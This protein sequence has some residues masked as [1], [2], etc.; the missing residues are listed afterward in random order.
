MSAI[1]P[2]AKTKR[3]KKKNNNQV[4]LIPTTLYSYPNLTSDCMINFSSIKDFLSSSTK[5]SLSFG[6]GPSLDP[7]SLENS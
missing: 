1:P 2:K 3:I 4:A 5:A 7:T 6:L